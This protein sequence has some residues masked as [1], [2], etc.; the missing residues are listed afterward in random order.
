LQPLRELANTR[1]TYIRFAESARTPRL[2]LY[3]RSPTRARLMRTSTVSTILR[4]SHPTVRN[5]VCEILLI[6]NTPAA[7]QPDNF[8][9]LAHKCRGADTDQAHTAAPDTS[10]QFSTNLNHQTSSSDHGT[11]TVSRNKLPLTFSIS[12]YRANHRTARST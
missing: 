10:A 12:G 3:V 11:S 1:A 8:P 2:P 4:P 5:G 7:Y 9:H 6:Q